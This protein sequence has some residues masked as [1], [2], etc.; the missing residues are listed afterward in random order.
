MPSELEAAG[1]VDIQVHRE[2]IPIGPWLHTA[3]MREI[4]LWAQPFL[5][6]LIENVLLQRRDMDLSEVEARALKESSTQ[7]IHDPTIHAYLV[8]HSIWAQKPI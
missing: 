6:Y 3:R 2:R 1:F 4:G 8:W 7:V 5:E